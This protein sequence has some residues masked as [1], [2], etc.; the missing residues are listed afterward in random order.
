MPRFPAVVERDLTAC[1]CQLQGRHDA[2][3]P[4]PTTAY[5]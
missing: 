1:S 3:D 5:L 4:A 2:D